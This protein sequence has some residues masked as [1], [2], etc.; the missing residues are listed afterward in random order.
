MNFLQREAGIDFDS[1]VIDET[2]RRALGG[3]L[4]ARALVKDLE[5]GN[6]GVHQNNIKQAWRN[7]SLLNSLGIYNRDIRADN[8][9]S[10]RIIDFG[11]SWTEP[12][13]ILDNVDE[14]EAREQR[15]S[16]CAQFEEMAEQ[17]GIKTTSKVPLCGYNLRPRKKLWGSS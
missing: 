12:H 17:E 10:C 11:S 3:N 14:D 7:V 5:T 2:L 9:M 6:T 16:D 1:H 15:L 4:Q 13:A 8:F